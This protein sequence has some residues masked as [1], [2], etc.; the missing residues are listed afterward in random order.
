MPLTLGRRAALLSAL[1]MPALAQERTRLFLLGT[2][3]GP[4]VTPRER[5]P[6]AHVL[7]AGGVPYVIDCG[8]GV[9]DKLVLVGVDLTQLRH[10]FITHHH[11]DHNID[12]GT[13]FLLAW[14]SGLKTRV[15]T[16]GPPP[17]EK[18][19]RLAFELNAYDIGVRMEEE[20]RPDPRPLVVPHEFSVAGP[21]MQDAN[22]R[23]TAALVQH[24]IVEPAF[25]YRFDTSDRSI[26][27]SGDTKKSEDVIRLAQGAD[28]LV[29]EAMYM[30]ALDAMLAKNP[31]APTLRAHLLAGHTTAEEAG[32]VAAAAGV[33]QLVLSHLVPGDLSITDEMWIAEARKHYS[34]PIVV[35][36]DLMEV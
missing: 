8:Y 34:G 28:V 18:M 29:H 32:E 1:A 36:H 27:F 16:W 9:V 14:A 19:T 30:P 21:V 11:S 22:V 5:G 35:G 10:I 4:R 2:K 33:K 7:I 15:D 12:Y 13:L 20:G 6:T 3:G 23:V 24:G 25:A 31:N 17:I 26:V